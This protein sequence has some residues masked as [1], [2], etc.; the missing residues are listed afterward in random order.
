MASYS[1]TYEE[2][3]KNAPPHDTPEFIDYLREQNRVVFETNEWLVIENF[4]YHTPQR[5]WYTAFWKGCGFCK[6]EGCCAWWNALDELHYHDDWKD[7]EWLKK[8]ADKQTIKRFHI[9]IYKPLA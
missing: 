3:L 2:L 6:G 5:P 7:W 9:H 8:T 4:K 1:V